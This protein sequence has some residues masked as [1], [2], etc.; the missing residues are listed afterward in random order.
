MQRTAQKKDFEVIL[1]VKM[2]TRHLVGGPFGRE[3][4]AFVI[5]EL[6]R[7]EVARCGNF[8]SNFCVFLGENDPSKTVATAR[9]APKICQGQP[10]IWLSLFQILSK[11]VHFRLSYCRTRE[12]RFWPVQYLQYRF[13]EPILIK[14]AVCSKQNTWGLC[15]ALKSSFPVLLFS[16]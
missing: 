7:P 2:E 5:V 12:G 6:W 1:M 8:V 3:F 14:H 4:S 16:F 11:S 10:H 13:L 9:V 15:M